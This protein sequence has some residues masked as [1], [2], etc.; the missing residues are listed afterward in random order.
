[1]SEKTEGFDAIADVMKKQYPDQKALY[2]GTFCPLGWE[3]TI[4]WTVWKSGRVKKACHT[5]IM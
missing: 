4:P 5:G 1:M 3:E 2:Y